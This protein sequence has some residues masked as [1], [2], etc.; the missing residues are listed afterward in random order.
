MIL[1]VALTQTQPGDVYRLNLELGIT[2]GDGNTKVEQLEM[3][4]TRERFEV[5]VEGEPQAVVLDPN[6]WALVKGA[7]RAPIGLKVFLT[8]LAIADDIGAILVIALFYTE[9]VSLGALTLAGVF[10]VL[11]FVANRAGIRRPEIYIALG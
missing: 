10:L 3:T 8:A 5:A 2:D 6:V 11:I 1:D 7:A 9:K 4:E